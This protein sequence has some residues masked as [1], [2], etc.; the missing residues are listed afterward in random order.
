MA[1]N[2]TGPA[3]R[4]CDIRAGGGLPRGSAGDQGEVAACTA[5]RIRSASSWSAPVGAVSPVVGPRITPSL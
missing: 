4:S 5:L 3:L 1:G 2:A